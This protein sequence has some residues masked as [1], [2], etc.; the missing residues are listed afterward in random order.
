MAKVKQCFAIGRTPE[1]RA[2]AIAASRKNSK[3]PEWRIR[4]SIATKSA[5]ADPEIKERHRIAMAEREKRI[6]NFSGGNGDTPPDKVLEI[7]QRL[8]PLGYIMEYP[9]KTKGHGT[10]HSVPTCY[11]VDFGHPQKK[12]AVEVDGPCHRGY[13]KQ[14]LDAKKTEVLESL[15]WKVARIKH[16]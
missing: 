4:V 7:A 2:R 8:T 12:I 1:V 5:M 16:D 9:I 10:Q 3:D 14:V 13:A 15:G 6:R 11:K